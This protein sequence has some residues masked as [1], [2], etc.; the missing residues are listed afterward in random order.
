MSDL[1]PMPATMAPF[2]TVTCLCT[3]SSI[4]VAQ[5]LADSL[6]AV[7]QWLADSLIAVQASLPRDN[8]FVRSVYILSCDQ[9]I[10]P[11]QTMSG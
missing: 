3:Y 8:I 1:R 4:A 11:Q 5:W 9:N 6:I 2:R 10:R 7:A